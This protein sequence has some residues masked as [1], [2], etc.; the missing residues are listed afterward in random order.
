M[1]GVER[2]ELPALWSQTRC[3]TRLRYTPTLLSY[4]PCYGISSIHRVQNTIYFTFLTEAAGFYS[5]TSGSWR[6][7]P[8]PRPNR[9]ASPPPI[10]KTYFAGIF[11]RRGVRLWGAA[12]AIVVTSLPSAAKNSISS[13]IGVFFIQNDRGAA[14][15][16][17]NSIPLCGANGG[18]NISPNLC[19]SGVWAKRTSNFKGVCCPPC[20]SIILPL[21]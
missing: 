20:N 5:L 21:V 2:F 12:L 18:L 1:V 16:K 7:V 13:A 14:S 8:A 6:R 4:P 17:M 15:S 9:L 19:C 3:A 11:D 10:S